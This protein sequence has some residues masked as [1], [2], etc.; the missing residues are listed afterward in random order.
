MALLSS[1]VASV[2]G[3]GPGIGHAAARLYADKGTA[4][5]PAGWPET[6]CRFG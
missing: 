5:I 6:Q 1:K 2:T 4:V 3:A